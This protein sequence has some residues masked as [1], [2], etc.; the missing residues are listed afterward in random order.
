CRRKP[1]VAALTAALLLLVLMVAVGSSLLAV[2]LGAA[3]DQSE[4]D[5][6][7]AEQA[8]LGGKHK[9]WQAHLAA[10]QARRMRPQPRPRLPGLRAVGEALAL[11]VPPGRSRDELRTEALAC[12]CL[13]DL[14]PAS[15]WDGCPLGSAGFAIDAA[16]ARYARGDKDGNVS[17]RRL[18]DD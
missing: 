14:E 6:T 9:L 15:E 4:R 1:A 8:E 16:F 3:L 2:R 7:R 5:R 12:L 11:P 18:S 13:P 17:V 10:A